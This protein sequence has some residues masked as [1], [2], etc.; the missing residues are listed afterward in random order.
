MSEQEDGS[1]GGSGALGTV[2]L[3]IASRREFLDSVHSLSEHLIEA[4]G[5]ASDDTYW[6]V[7]AV[8]EAVTN[9]VIHG[10]RERP[11]TRVDVAFELGDDRIRITI[12]DQGQGFDPESLPDPVSEEHLMDSSGRGI[13]LMNQLMDE[14]SYD[15]P[16]DGG[17]T[18]SMMRRVRSGDGSADG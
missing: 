15:F 5:F 16:A 13:F 14:V 8:R 9:A 18:I 4:V 6:M 11:G 1:G 7:T 3:S 17:T 2:R 12:S 10:N